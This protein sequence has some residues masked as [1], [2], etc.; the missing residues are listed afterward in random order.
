MI[1]L[2]KSKNPNYHEYTKIKTI[3]SIFSFFDIYVF[4]KKLT[5]ILKEKGLHLDISIISLSPPIKQKIIKSD[6][7]ILYL[8][9]EKFSSIENIFVMMEYFI[10]DLVII[11]FQDILSIDVYVRVNNL[12]TCLLKNIFDISR[13]S[14]KLKIR[15][16]EKNT[17][18]NIDKLFKL[19]SNVGKLGLPINTL[20]SCYFDSLIIVLLVGDDTY[21]KDI[22]F[23]TNVFED[24]GDISS[25]KN[26]RILE[27]IHTKEEFERYSNLI[28]KQLVYNFNKI[29]VGKKNYHCDTFRDIL[30]LIDPS[31]KSKSGRYKSYTPGEIYSNLSIIFP[32]LNI[33]TP[34][35]I[36][37]KVENKKYNMFLMYDFINPLISDSEI[38][39][40][41]IDSNFLVFQLGVYPKIENYGYSKKDKVSF[42]KYDKGKMSIKTDHIIKKRYFAEYILSGKYR[43]FGAICNEGYISTETKYF[44]GSHYTAY[45]R[46]F[47]DK[48]NWYYY[49]DLGPIFKKIGNI[50]KNIFLDLK[51]KRSEMLFYTR[52]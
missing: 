27:Y 9:D 23:N 1:D 49:N 24:N 13:Q 11:M 40:E 16:E 42:I 37:N 10:V 12:R 44:S 21:L 3:N 7:T 43:L 39:W 20:N 34:T 36:F 2:W 14:Q 51:T 15:F 45:L 47:F 50:P 25:F 30:Y 38:L 19:Y 35:N 41:N 28:Q 22:L 33:D 17:K 4:N 48:E 32:K 5:E 31:I 8:L 52:V 26:P 46:P 18:I 6:N 29:L